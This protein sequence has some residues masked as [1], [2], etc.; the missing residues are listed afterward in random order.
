MCN[1]IP[2]SSFYFLFDFLSNFYLYNYDIVSVLPVLI[3]C[4]GISTVSINLIFYS[5]KKLG[6]KIIQNA[7]TIGTILAGT[8]TTIDAALNISDR[9]KGNG[10]SGNSGSS[11]N[12]GGGSSNNE[13]GSSK[14]NTGK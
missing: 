6:E 13:E 10:N 4:G 1:F 2:L 8:V 9:L 3:F 5:A 14:N 12:D 7:G 11:N